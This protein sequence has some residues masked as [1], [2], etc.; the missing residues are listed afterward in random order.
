MIGLTRFS[1]LLAPAT[2]RANRDADHA[3]RLA[4]AHSVIAAQL[5]E[6]DALEKQVLAAEAELA[7]RQRE[8]ERLEAEHDALVL[9]Y[10]LRAEEQRVAQQNEHAS[11]D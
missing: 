4:E 7:E 3:K 9:E 2:K 5:V 1:G 8:H 6:R 10:L 11:T